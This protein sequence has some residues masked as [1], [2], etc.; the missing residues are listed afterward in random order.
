MSDDA[1][2]Y[3]FAS[4]HRA[5]VLFSQVTNSNNGLISFFEKDNIQFK[6]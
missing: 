2:T 6:I 4:N 1:L 5:T 3:Q